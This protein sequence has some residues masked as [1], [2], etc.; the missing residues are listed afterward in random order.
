MFVCHVC[1][2]K[3]FSIFLAYR[4]GEGGFP[5]IS[6]L[7]YDSSIGLKMSVTLNGVEWL[8]LNRVFWCWLCKFWRCWILDRLWWWC[9]TATAAAGET[10]FCGEV[11]FV[12]GLG[13]GSNW[14]W[15][16][17][18]VSISFWDKLITKSDS[19]P[20]LVSS[21][22][23]IARKPRRSLNWSIIFDADIRKTLVHSSLSSYCIYKNTNENNM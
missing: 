3:I 15:W 9:A 5:L 18:V 2:H 22:S 8:L 10:E 21:S 13:S 14:C 17:A 6:N 20:K 11:S 16:E 23:G 19:C 4:N 1:W 7:R 12:V